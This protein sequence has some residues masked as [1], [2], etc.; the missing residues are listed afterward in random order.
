[1][2]VDMR[3][4]YPLH[5]YGCWGRTRRQTGRLVRCGT[6]TD[7]LLAALVAFY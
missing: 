6:G 5:G 3:D 2:V 7:E 4:E 1:M